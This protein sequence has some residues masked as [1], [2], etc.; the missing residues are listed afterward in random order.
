MIESGKFT[1]RDREFE[2]HAVVEAMLDMLAYRACQRGLELLSLVD[3]DVPAWL[4]GDA[5]ALR[6][7]LLNLLGNAIKFTDYGVIDLRVSVVARS[8]QHCRLRFAV[9]DTGAGMSA[10]RQAALFQP[11]THGDASPRRHEGGVGLGLSICKS[12]IESMQGTIGVESVRSGAR[13]N[14]PTARSPRKTRPP[15]TRSPGGGA[16]WWMTTRWRA[17]RCSPSSRPWA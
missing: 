16:W 9:R 7:I 11:Y 10:E 4:R 2:L 12:L 13:W 3:E 17:A 6:Q 14:L 5:L 15:A 1:P 8:P